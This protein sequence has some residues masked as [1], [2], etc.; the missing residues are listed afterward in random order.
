MKHRKQI[1][2]GTTIK[3]DTTFEGIRMLFKRVFQKYT[4][5]SSPTLEITRW[6]MNILLFLSNVHRYALVEFL[7]F[8]K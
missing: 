5:L 7:N 4:F 8:R 2:R 6:N 1:Y 3:T